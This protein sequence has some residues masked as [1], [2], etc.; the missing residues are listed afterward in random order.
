MNYEER[1]IAFIDILG[2]K[3]IVQN[4]SSDSVELERLN[5]ALNY[6]LKLKKE[7][8]KEPYG[9]NW[10]GME[11]TMFSDSIVISYP[12]NGHG[13][14]FYILLEIALI[15]IEI[16]NKGYIFRGGITV[17]SLVHKGD[18]CFGPAMNCAVDLEKKAK[19]PRIIIEKQ[20]FEK[21]L[22]YPGY[23]NTPDQEVEYLAYLVLLDDGIFIKDS[24]SV[25]IL[26][27]LALHNE[28]DDED[29]YILL[30]LKTRQLIIEQYNSACSIQN[31]DERENIRQ[32]YI[33]FAG[34]YNYIVERVLKNYSEYMLNINQ[35]Q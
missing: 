10:M 5:N 19:Y 24:E 26:N 6:I 4:T 14:A 22:Q 12:A 34:Y 28:I 3:N 33:W 1:Y 30:I 21:G 23:A 7:N 16:L 8:Y 11:F 18:I 2:F 35:F 31:T 27:Y 13:N 20:V 25:F 17:G 29:A 32:K 15:C 9:N